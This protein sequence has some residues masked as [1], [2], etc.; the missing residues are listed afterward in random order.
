VNIYPRQGSGFAKRLADPT[1]ST[2]SYMSA[3]S[4]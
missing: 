4:Q 2:N 3:S 1:T